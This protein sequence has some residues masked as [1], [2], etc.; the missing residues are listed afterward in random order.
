MAKLW[1]NEMN[2]KIMDDDLSSITNIR[3]QIF[4]IDSQKEL[5]DSHKKLLENFQK[6]NSGG[7]QEKKSWENSRMNSDVIPRS[8]LSRISRRNL[9]GF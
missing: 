8:K 7:F 6:K 1:T 5:L 9:E 2:G 3:Y 4:L